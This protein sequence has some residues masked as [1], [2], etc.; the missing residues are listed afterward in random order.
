MNKEYIEAFT[1]D[2]FCENPQEAMVAYTALNKLKNNFFDHK[3]VNNVFQSPDWEYSAAEAY[4]FSKVYIGILKNEILLLPI[5]LGDK[6][7]NDIEIMQ[8]NLKLSYLP[9]D[10]YAEFLPCDGPIVDSSDG[11]LNWDKDV[12]F[13]DSKG[14]ENIIKENS[15]PLE[16]GYTNPFTT[17]MHLERDGGVARWPYESDEILL[18]VKKEKM[19]RVSE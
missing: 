18:F 19:E 12:I 15:I 9:N 7:S 4:Y 3:L 8:N 5:K 2:I 6:P 14:N 11:F 16:V 10:F 1:D 13:Y 17:F